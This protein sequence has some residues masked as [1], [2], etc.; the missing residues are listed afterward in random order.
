MLRLTIQ[1]AIIVTILTYQPIINNYTKYMQ[2]WNLKNGVESVDVS[3]LGNQEE[4]CEDEQA[5][6]IKYFV[7]KNKDI[8]KVEA[9]NKTML[10]LGSFK[11]NDYLT[12]AAM[13]NLPE[14]KVANVIY[15]PV[16]NPSGFVHSAPNTYPKGIDISDDFPLLGYLGV[17]Y[18]NRSSAVKILDHIF[19]TFKI[20]LTI[21]LKQGPPSLTHSW[22]MIHTKQSQPT[23]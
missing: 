17:K 22:T 16:P 7:Y 23:I 3:H 9:R 2:L 1:L 19:R 13:L 18:C 21:Q 20:D 4:K 8:A 6:S 5:C 15:F 10:V 14:L 12:P 11:G